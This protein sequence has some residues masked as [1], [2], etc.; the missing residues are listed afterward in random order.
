MGTLVL[1]RLRLVFTSYGNQSSVN[2]FKKTCFDKGWKYK[3]IIHGN[4]ICFKTML[5]SLYDT[6]PYK[7]DLPLACTNVLIIIYKYILIFFIE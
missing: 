3:I 4:Q 5:A 1:N 6:Q 2:K 7:I